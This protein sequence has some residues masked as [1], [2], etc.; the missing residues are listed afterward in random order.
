MCTTT[1]REISDSEG[2]ASV[3]FLG[4]QRKG[5]NEWNVAL[6]NIVARAH[7]KTKFKEVIMIINKKSASEKVEF[8]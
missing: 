6:F 7:K 4:S 5:G 3:R 2:L 1:T 8:I